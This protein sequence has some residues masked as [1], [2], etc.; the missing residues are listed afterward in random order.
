MKKMICTLL[1]CALAL[2]CAACSMDKK[3]T[4]PNTTAETEST[5]EK[6]IVQ[7]TRQISAPVMQ[8]E[9]WHEYESATLDGESETE[10]RMLL[11]SD[12]TAD[13]TVIYDENGKKYAEL[14]GVIVYNENQTAFDNIQLNQDYNGIVY[15]EKSTGTVGKD[16]RRYQSIMGECPTETGIWY[17]YCYALDFENY[18]VL[19]T[20]Y[21]DEQYKEIPAAY[22]DILASITVNP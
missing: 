15:S 5:T 3:E 10:I 8:T 21:A 13:G 18:A 14:V 7:T 6:A 19:I 9:N 12:H 2:S 11:P 16:N 1:A 20:L 22:Q 4:A 17:S